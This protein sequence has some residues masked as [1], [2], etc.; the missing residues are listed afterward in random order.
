LG[1]LPFDP[2]LFSTACIIK[3]P[4]NAASMPF[5][6]ATQL[7]QPQRPAYTTQAACQ[8]RSIARCI[9]RLALHGLLNSKSLVSGS[10]VELLGLIVYKP[11]PDLIFSP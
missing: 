10:G 5:V 1:G 11:M 6:V 4:T 2:N 7:R 8:L 3:S 9:P